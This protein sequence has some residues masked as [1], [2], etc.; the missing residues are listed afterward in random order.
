MSQSRGARTL[1]RIRPPLAPVLAI[2]GLVAACD[3]RP[4]SPEVV[5]VTRAAGH[6]HRFDLTVRLDSPPPSHE[7][8]D[9]FLLF[10][11][12]L[13]MQN[14]IDSVRIDAARI[15]EEVKNVSR[16]VAFGVGSFQDYSPPDSPWRLH[17]DLTGDF[18]RLQ[19]ALGEVSLG[20]GRDLPEAYARGLFESRFLSWRRDA[21]RF[22]VLF[23]DAP[24]HDPDFY[25]TDYGIDAG[26]D[27]V[28]GTADDLRLAA[29]V[30]ELRGDGIVVIS[31]HDSPRWFRQNKP[32][33]EDAIR[34]FEF[35]S[36]ETGGVAKP[37]GHPEEV[38]K[39]IAA[40]IREAYQPTPALFVP[41]DRRSWVSSGPA[42]RRVSSLPTF[43]FA[44]TVTPPDDT[45]AG[46]YQFPLS[47]GYAGV[48]RQSEEIGRTRLTVRVP[49]RWSFWRW[50]LP[51]AW[52]VLVPLALFLR[53]RSS[54]FGVGPRLYRNRQGRR[55]L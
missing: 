6:S 8:I 3:R 54:R 11:A 43:R 31:V 38:S 33:L 24:A 26:R 49:D 37:I 39:A 48:F 4:V 23:G 28:V 15:L 14:V 27:G 53:R 52:L 50:A 9:V 12:T 20:D 41:R 47:V 29:T 17:Q 13:S 45:A 34:G 35:I 25:G 40:G 5:E 21:R 2:L 32:R 46:V 44:V 42:V 16:N 18:E 22:I 10:D 36:R 1:L 19:R 55:L 7:P 30:E 51:I